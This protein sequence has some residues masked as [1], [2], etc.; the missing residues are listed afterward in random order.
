MVVAQGDKLPLHYAA[1]NG[2]SLEVVNLLL[3]S[4]TG[5][6]STSDKVPPAEP[7]H[8]PL[9]L[10]ISRGTAAHTVLR[11]ICATRC[12]PAQS[13]GLALHYAAAKGA[14]LEVVTLLFEAYKAAATKGDQAR[15]CSV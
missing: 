2:A 14:S 15:L 4:D 8:C 5:L 10:T 12:A 13:G 3:G 9:F 6:A 7:A 11:L 1:E